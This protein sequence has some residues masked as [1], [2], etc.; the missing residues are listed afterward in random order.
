[1]LEKI[2]LFFDKLEDKTRRWLSHRPLLYAL[3]G[4]VFFFGE[5]F[6]I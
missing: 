6:G 2:L 1:M 3:I 5:E 4:G